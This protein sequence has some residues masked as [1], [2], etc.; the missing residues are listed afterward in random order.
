MEVQA[1]RNPTAAIPLVVLLSLL[2]YPGIGHLLLGRRGQALL[3]AALFTL[4]TLGVL[5][6][7]QH[8]AA[9]VAQLLAQAQQAA[10]RGE[11]WVPTVPRPVFGPWSLVSGA[12]WL[13]AAIHAGKL[14]AKARQ[15]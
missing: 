5:Y 14:A 2:V 9:E 8:L 6:D 1:P 12:V 7:N 11:V 4:A 10:E 13:G 3:L 15:A